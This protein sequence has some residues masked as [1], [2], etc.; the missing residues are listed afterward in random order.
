MPDRGKII[1][2]QSHSVVKQ[3]RILAILDSGEADHRIHFP[4][5]H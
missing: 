4:S 1:Q 5:E 3:K 2:V